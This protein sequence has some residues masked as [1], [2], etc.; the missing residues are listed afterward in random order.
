[1]PSTSTSPR[2]P[3]S[4]RSTSTPTCARLRCCD[5]LQSLDEEFE[6]LSNYFIY[7]TYKKYHY[8]FKNKSI[9]NKLKFTVQNIM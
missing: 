3:C 4:R 1:M 5:L 9:K 7:R 6:Q 2:R 8:S